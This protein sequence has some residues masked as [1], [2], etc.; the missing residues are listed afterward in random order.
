MPWTFWTKAPSI[1][2]PLAQHVSNSAGSK[3]TAGI[4]WFRQ[5]NLPWKEVV[6]VGH[7]SSRVELQEGPGVII[8]KSWQ[9]PVYGLVTAMTVLCRGLSGFLFH[10]GQKV[11]I[12]KFHVLIFKPSFHS[13]RIILWEEFISNKLYWQKNG[14][15][16]YLWQ[17]SVRGY[18]TWGTVRTLQLR[19][20]SGQHNQ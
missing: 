17:A 12:F 14:N 3:A 16:H 8:N 2:V 9:L 15:K 19:Y 20:R 1:Q 10:S 13:S 18:G 4:L 6:A 5:C 11:T 7:I